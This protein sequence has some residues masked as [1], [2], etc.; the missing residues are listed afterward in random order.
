MKN[1]LISD[2]KKMFA[3]IKRDQKNLIALSKEYKQNIINA[4]L[5]KELYKHHGKIEAEENEYFV[6]PENEDIN[7]TGS[8]RIKMLD[9]NYLLSDEDMEIMNS[10][11]YSRLKND[12]I[13]IDLCPER[14][15]IEEPENII[16][17]YKFEQR[18]RDIDKELIEKFK[19]FTGFQENQLYVL[20]TRKEYIDF[21]FKA[22]SEFE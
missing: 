6:A 2:I 7:G 21:I 10:R 19:P 5:I 13:M 15:E 4:N 3:Y 18:N 11:V 17:S 22:I 9:D 20:S 14:L 1:I 8:S 12:P 16:Y